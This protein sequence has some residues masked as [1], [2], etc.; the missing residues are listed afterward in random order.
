[1]DRPSD[2]NP[3]SLQDLQLHGAVGLGADVDTVW[4][5]LEG[6]YS[7]STLLGFPNV[8]VS[9]DGKD[10]TSSSVLFPKEFGS[11]SGLELTARPGS[12]F[13][14][15]PS[16]PKFATGTNAVPFDSGHLE[17]VV[18]GVAEL[19]GLTA[20]DVLA[21]RVFRVDVGA[22][23]PVPR[24][25]ALY[26]AALEP[27]ARWRKKVDK[28]GSVVV[29]TKRS[30]IAVYDKR[31]QCE[32]RGMA[33]AGVYGDG[34]LARVERRFLSQVDRQIGQRATVGSLFDPDVLAALGARL[35]ED[36]TR[37]P[38]RPR[39][40]PRTCHTPTQLVAVL[41][42]H[43][44][45]TMG[46]APAVLSSIDAARV[47]GDLTSNQATR[48]RGRVRDIGEGERDRD[49]DDLGRELQ[50]AVAAVVGP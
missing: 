26:T 32:K 28:A 35:V 20:D 49:P 15:V 46:G 44:I 9:G 39:L 14:K 33:V 16:V 17:A 8:V 5:G 2:N 50:R 30:Q 31:E 41:A 13:V 7:P 12:L 1:M 3:P 18:Q 38:F 48:M 42:A 23:V 29:G 36:V 10:W 25:V 34:P 45:E 43:G 37:I 19:V 11:L 40:L 22:N 47:A 24:P 27:P 4:F 21:G 6:P